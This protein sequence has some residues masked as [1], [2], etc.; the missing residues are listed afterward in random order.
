MTGKFYLNRLFGGVLLAEQR[1]EEARRQ[2][3]AAVEN[4]G[5]TT[6]AIFGECSFVTRSSSK[7]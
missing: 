4:A 6:R 3:S 7:A 2:Y 1:L 5:L